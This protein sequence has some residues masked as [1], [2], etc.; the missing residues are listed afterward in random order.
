MVTDEI[1]RTIRHSRQKISQHE[2]LAAAAVDAGM[3]VERTASGVQPHSGGEAHPVAFAKERRSGGMEY[4]DTFATDRPVMFCVAAAGAGFNGHLAT[5][6]TV[7]HGDALVSAGDGTLRLIDTAGGD[8]QT[9][10]LGTVD[11]KEEATNR[12]TQYGGSTTIDNSGGS[13]PIPVPVEVV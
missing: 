9:M 8:T 6:E 5:G 11:M 10:V 2:E 3:L 4:G 7:N 13:S 1:F 12:P